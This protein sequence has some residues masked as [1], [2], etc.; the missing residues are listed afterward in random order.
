MWESSAN[1]VV[2]QLIICLHLKLKQVIVHREIPITVICPLQGDTKPH[3]CLCKRQIHDQT[4]CQASVV[5]TQLQW[6]IFL[7]PVK[8]DDFSIICDH[9]HVPNDAALA[10]PTGSRRVEDCIGVWLLVVWAR[11]LL[12]NYYQGRKIYSNYCNNCD[13]AGR[14]GCAFRAD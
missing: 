12:D 3:G 4:E 9:V 13:G 5:G 7:C 8:H 2:A 10:L 11:D 6:N 1:S 14:E